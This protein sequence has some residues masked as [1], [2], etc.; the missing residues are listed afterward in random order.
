VVRQRSA[1]PLFRGSNPRAALRVIALRVFTS[2]RRGLRVLTRDAKTCQREDDFRRGGEI[3]RRTGLKI[4]GPARVVSVRVRPSAFEIN[5]LQ[6]L[7][8]PGIFNSV[9]H[10]ALTLPHFSDS[11]FPSEFDRAS[12][13]LQIDPYP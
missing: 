10:F 3:G 7:V 13:Q 12:G 5:N 2:P 6:P 8:L 9:L 4:L 11:T 1:K